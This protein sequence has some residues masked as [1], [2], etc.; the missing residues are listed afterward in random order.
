MSELASKLDVDAV[1]GADG[2]IARYIDGFQPRASQLDMA[3]LIDR[4]IH[5]RE[6][7]IIEAATG[8]GKSFAYLTP[9]FLN[10][11]K[12]VISTGTKNLQD[13]LFTKDI[14]LINKTI[15]SGK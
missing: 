13:Q 1:I 9:L 15:V 4:S 5:N 14:P 11:I 3:R 6:H 8:I 2:I 10:D 12:A 7:H